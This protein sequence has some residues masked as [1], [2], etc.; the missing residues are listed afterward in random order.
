[1]SII[2]WNTESVMAQYGELKAQG[3]SGLEA[4][5]ALR[6]P[7]WHLLGSRCDCGFLTLPNR[8]YIKGHDAKGDVVQRS[9][10][11]A[12]KAYLEVYGKVAPGSAKP[13]PESSRNAEGIAG[14]QE[15]TEAQGVTQEGLKTCN[16]CNKPLH[17]RGNVCNAC[18]QAAYRGRRG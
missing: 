1:M 18:R 2:T 6:G 13:S 12:E 14:A 11:E 3:L 10:V 5:R 4:S 9:Q 17:N 15:K 16:A 8:F 7:H